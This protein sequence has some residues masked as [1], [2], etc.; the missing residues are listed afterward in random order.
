VI[1][2]RLTARILGLLLIVLPLIIDVSCIVFVRSEH[3]LRLG[4]VMLI[5]APSVPFLVGGILLLRRAA[6]MNG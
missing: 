5:L 1:T 6:R 4:F 3:R 2:D